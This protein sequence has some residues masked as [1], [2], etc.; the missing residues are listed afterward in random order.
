MSAPGTS[1]K[2]YE[3]AD[4]YLA[5]LRDLAGREDLAPEI[6]A[7]TLEAVQG[8]V[9]VK[10]CNVAA[11]VRNV[12]A[13]AD[14]LA[15]RA[16]ELEARAKR[17]AALADGLKGY[18]AANLLRCGL[19]EAKHGDTLVKLRANPPS[20]AIQDEAAIPGQFKTT[21]PPAPPPQAKPDKTAIKEAIKAARE[22]HDARLAA[23]APGE[24]APAFVNPVPGAELLK[25]YRVEIL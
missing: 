11:F 1:V 10:A 25:S 14:F 2:L 17:A 24:P 3:V 22:A 8:E 6:I 19:K 13:E 16:A 12:E 7:D 15:G 21:P 5:A 9:Q 20:V 4:T 23:L 18:L